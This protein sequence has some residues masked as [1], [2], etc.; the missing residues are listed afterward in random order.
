MRCMFLE[1]H[2]C[3]HTTGE[4][5]LCCISKEPSKNNNITNMSPREWLDS[6]YVRNVKSQLSNGWPSSCIVCQQKEEQGL[7]SKRSLQPLHSD[8]EI[9]YIDLRL[10]NTCNLRCQM[11][12]PVS[13]SKILA[14]AI[15]IEKTSRSPW[16]EILSNLSTTNWSDR[17]ELL[18]DIVKYPLTEIYFT[19]GEPMLV[20][21]I[22][23]FLEKLQKVNPNCKLRFNSNGTII[24]DALNQQL[25]KFN[26]VKISLSIDAIEGRLEYIRYGTKWNTIQENLKIF[27]DIADVDITPTISVYNVLYINELYD[28]IKL[29][30]LDVIP[31]ILTGPNYLAVNN[32]PNKELINFQPAKW[33][34]DKPYDQNATDKFRSYVVQLDTYRK[35]NINDHLPE[36][37]KIYG[38]N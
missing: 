34:L 2:V 4:Y 7:S 31:N 5:R 19:G 33:L 32:F 8:T 25:K 24:N 35:I 9:H 11:C 22:H 15:G 36:L 3:I 13:S 20:K 38:L 28:W 12:W 27:R 37:A 17:L 16:H 18:D 1:N 6:D 10:G 23:L 14:D 26:D 29:H 21:G 30:N